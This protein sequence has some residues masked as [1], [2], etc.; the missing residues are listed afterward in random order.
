MYYVSCADLCMLYSVLWIC[1]GFH[2]DPDPD[3]SS[4]QIQVRIRIQV[5]T[6]ADPDPTSKS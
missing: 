5:P 6:Y 4:M 2:M 3:F 1:I